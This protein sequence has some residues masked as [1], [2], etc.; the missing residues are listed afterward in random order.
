MQT[1]THSIHDILAKNATSFL[2]LHFNELM[3]GA[4]QK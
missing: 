3:H 1:K 2:F 4:K